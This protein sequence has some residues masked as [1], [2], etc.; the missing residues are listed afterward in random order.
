MN[1][2]IRNAKE[3]LANLLRKRVIIFFIIIEFLQKVIFALNL[4]T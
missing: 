1:I 2:K 3:A 4:K